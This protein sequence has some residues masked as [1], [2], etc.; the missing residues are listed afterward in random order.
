[1]SATRLLRA[2]R[3]LRRSLTAL[4]K[5]CAA[6][7]Q[8]FATSSARRAGPGAGSGQSARA[9]SAT[10]SLSSVLS[11][12]AVASFLGWSVSEFQHRGFPGAF[13][14]DGA[15][16]ASRYASMRE[17][18][19]ALREIRQEIEGEDIISTDPDDLHAHGYSEWSTTNPEGLPVAVAYPRSTEQVSTIARI[20]HKYR[21][22]IIPYSGGSSLEGNFSAPFGGISVD[23]AYMDK[24]VQL[25]KDDMDV[26][27]QPS[28][29][30]QD[31]NEQLAKMGS[32]LFFPIDPG[33]SAKIGGM[34]GT[35]CSGTN[36]VKYG[37]MKDWVINLTVVL[38]DGTVIKT[39]R[40]PRKSSA[41]YNLNGLF[42]GSEGT[43]GLVTEATLK[44]AVIPEEV[45]VAVV[46][47]PSI[48]DAA[49]AATEVM[50]RGIPVAA[51]EIM[52]EVQMKV[53]NMGGATAPRVWK[54]MP[55]LFFK[56]SGTKAGVKEQIRL[57]QKITKANKGSNFEFAKDEREQKLLWSARKESLWSMLALRK[58]GEEVWS[59]DVAV[60]FSR[61]ADIIEVS[62]KEMD[63]LGLFASILGHIGDGNFHESI[64]YNGRDKAE[65]DRVEA[66]VK[67]M[68]KRA[69]EMEGTCTGEHSIG[70]G[71]KE[72]LVWEVGHDTL[73]VM[74]AIKSAL[75]PHW[76]MN[77]GKIFDRQG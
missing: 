69:L 4:D 30:W 28:I 59:T 13:L 12:A 58:E 63:D 37:T 25:N 42:V 54:E 29:G 3:P 74:K 61:L 8:P 32:G 48:R 6:G 52:D 53:V 40:R 62:K 64:I 50:Q 16:P 33:P 11:V 19:Q 77:P 51:M 73:G 67:N 47:F 35:N 65:R 9:S 55:T 60:P 5:P 10:W 71:K 68:V 46:T 57:V 15:F 76:I 44:L 49:A 56:F 17:M 1:M 2:G 14:L 34:I 43:L 18:E 66:C 20:C 39:R 7:R 26:V 72:S 23:F 45:S 21:V 75:D 24:I 36:A 38:A 70:W 31:L 22:P 27:V 41:G